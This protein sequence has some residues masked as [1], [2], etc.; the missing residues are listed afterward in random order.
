MTR[1]KQIEAEV[2]T[3]I[4]ETNMKRVSKTKKAQDVK[5]AQVDVNLE[6]A[7]Q[8]SPFVAK[9]KKKAKKDDR[10][11]VK[12][13]MGVLNGT[14]DAETVQIGSNV[15]EVRLMG[16]VSESTFSEGGIVRLIVDILYDS[17]D[18]VRLTKVGKGKNGLPFYRL[19][20]RV[21]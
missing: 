3:K 15:V 14:P 20:T 9:S 21:K 16:R 19:S 17:E 6:M 1:Y 2:K 11:S 4:E 18:K 8:P 13:L 10:F 12:W 7:K 5:Q